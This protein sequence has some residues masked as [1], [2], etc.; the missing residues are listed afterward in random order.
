MPIHKNNRSELRELNKLL[1]ERCKKLEEIEN[2]PNFD[3]YTDYLLGYRR[4]A[5]LHVAKCICI[6]YPNWDAEKLVK[7]TRLAINSGVNG[8]TV[9][10][11]KAMVQK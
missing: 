6:F 4:S 8:F 10:K 9:E 5:A 1:I 3:K 2:D 7:A 11:M